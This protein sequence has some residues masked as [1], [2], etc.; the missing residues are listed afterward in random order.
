MKEDDAAACKYDALEVF[1]KE[2]PA[3]ADFIDFLNTI[4]AM[5]VSHSPLDSDAEKRKFDQNAV[6]QRL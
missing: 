4:A 6:T 5:K 3:A 1:R 2:N